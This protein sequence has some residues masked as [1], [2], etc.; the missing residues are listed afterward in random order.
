MGIQVVRVPTTL[1]FASL[2]GACVAF[3]DLLAVAAVE[4]K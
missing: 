3:D 4:S 2:F 1:N